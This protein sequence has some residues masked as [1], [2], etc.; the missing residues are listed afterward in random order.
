MTMPGQEYAG[1]FVDKF[2]ARAG[3]VWKLGKVNKP[4]LIS[5]NDKKALQA[6]AVAFLLLV[7]V[8]VEVHLGF[9]LR[10]LL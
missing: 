5:M 2:S 7:F 10:N 9:N 8:M 3:F 4:S 1:D 6:K